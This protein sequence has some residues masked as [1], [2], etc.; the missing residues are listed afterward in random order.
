M[1]ETFKTKGVASID[2]LR[3]ICIEEGVDMH[4]CQM[5]VDVFGFTKDDFIDDVTSWCGAASFLPT[6]RESDVTLFI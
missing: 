6:A 3:E 5:T 1:K 2:D 4:A